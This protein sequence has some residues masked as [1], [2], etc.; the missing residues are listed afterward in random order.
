MEQET[1][2]LESL[3][4][5]EYKSVEA[6]PMTRFKLSAIFFLLAL[7][8]PAIA[9]STAD[10]IFSDAQASAAIQKKNVFLIFSASWCGPCHQLDAF[11]QAPDMQPIIDKYFVVAR[12]HIAE[13]ASKH[14][15]RN[16]PGSDAL[17]HK[18]TG[19]DPKNTGV[20]FI[21]LVDSTGKPVV[22]SDRPVPGAAAENI[23]YPFLPE[24]IGWFM[25]MLKR[26]A[27][28]MPAAE[29]QSIKAWLTK[30]AESQAQ[31]SHS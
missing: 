4:S 23:G 7:A 13:E 18:L 3:S 11:L 2:F 16:T 21:V 14:P 15:E 9:Q 27:P 29:A 5:Q 28:S 20:P 22:N 8:L 10:K 26:G 1:K 19:N 30:A 6:T 31:A 12:V 25:E 17:L 24:E